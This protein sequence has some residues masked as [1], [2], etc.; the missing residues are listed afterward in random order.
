MRTETTAE[1][2]VGHGSHAPTGLLDSAADHRA[3]I[4][5][6][7]SM[8]NYGVLTDEAVLMRGFGVPRSVSVSLGGRFRQAAPGAAPAPHIQQARAWLARQSRWPP[9]GRCTGLQQPHGR[10]GH[11]PGLAD[12]YGQSHAS[13]E[14][15]MNENEG[16]VEMSTVAWFVQRNRV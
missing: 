11:A 9:A 5:S 7:P 16:L 8:I 2:I 12:H 1:P 14:A 15:L 6:V 4:R 3:D 13:E 10:Q